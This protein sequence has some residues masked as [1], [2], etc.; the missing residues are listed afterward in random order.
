MA[1][2]LL[3]YGTVAVSTLFYA[4]WP[5]SEAVVAHSPISD[6]TLVAHAGGGLPGA[7]YS[8]SRESLDSSER[9][10]I[11]LIEVDIELTESG[12][13][14]LLHGWEDSHYRYFSKVP[15]LPQAM[16][17]P[18]PERAGTAEEFT[19]RRMRQGLTPMS[20]QDLMLWMDAHPHVRI[21]TDTKGDNMDVLTRLATSADSEKLSRI[22][23]QIYGLAEADAV[24]KLGYRSIILTAYKSPL[25]LPDLLAAAR[26]MELFALTIPWQRLADFENGRLPDDVTVFAHTVNDVELAQSL[27]SK[28]VDGVYTDYLVPEP[29]RQTAQKT[30][31]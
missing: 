16:R 8:N 24:T 21:I 10:G 27:V 26:D 17:G 11:D 31:H 12:D 28:G 20:G 25:P 15:R 9:F 2:R 14:V 22:I 7:T 18:W 6:I 5:T 13:L 3:V 1:G 4:A 19:S 23:P 29:L 30:V